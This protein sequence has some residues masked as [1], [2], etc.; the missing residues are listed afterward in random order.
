GGGTQA[1]GS[2]P[3]SAADA[4][5]PTTSTRIGPLTAADGASD[6]A[7]AP[8]AASFAAPEPVGAAP[9][10][11]SIFVNLPR[12]RYASLRWNSGVA[13]WRILNSSSSGW[14]AVLSP[15]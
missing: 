15:R 14:A 10:I 5:G 11:P 9:A 3:P 7:S 8:V 4:G 6:A 2:D 12:S 1:T 13:F